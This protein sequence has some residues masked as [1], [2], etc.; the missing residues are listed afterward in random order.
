M[1]GAEPEAHVRIPTP[2]PRAPGAIGR[3]YIELFARAFIFEIESPH[4]Q[5]RRARRESQQQASAQRGE[6]PFAAFRFAELGRTHQLA[7]L[8]LYGAPLFPQATASA[9]RATDTTAGTSTHT[10]DSKRLLGKAT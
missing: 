5:K 6:L 9:P 3:F 2:S 7:P 4:T 1:A 10:R 8:Q